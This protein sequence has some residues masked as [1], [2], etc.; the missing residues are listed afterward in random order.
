MS[1]FPISKVVHINHPAIIEIL[2]VSPQAVTP[3]DFPESSEDAGMSTTK[4]RGSVF[5]RD[6]CVQLNRSE[7]SRSGDLGIWSPTDGNYYSGMGVDA[8]IAAEDTPLMNH[9]VELSGVQRLEREQLAK[10]AAEKLEESDRRMIN[11]G[12]DLDKVKRLKRE[13]LAKLAAEEAEESA[14]KMVELAN[15]TFKQKALLIPHPRS[16]AAPWTKTNSKSKQKKHG[17]DSATGAK[18]EKPGV[19]E[20][21][22]IP[23]S[24]TVQNLAPLIQET[25]SN[26]NDISR[27]PS[28][29]A[30]DE[31]QFT[32]SGYASASGGKYYAEKHLNLERAHAGN[33]HTVRSPRQAQD[34]DSRTVISVATAVTTGIV[35][36][37]VHDICHD[38]YDRIAQRMDDGKWKYTSDSITE[39]LKAFAIKIGQGCSNDF[40]RTIMH[41][42]YSHHR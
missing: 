38:I 36:Q 33:T 39:L 6:E 40:N 11:C 7:T 12:M 37:A 30:V 22:T 42:V 20:E 23:V 29:A 2:I 25:R 16:Q 13:Q 17:R 10:L 4:N 8:A 21:F 32:D 41:F 28:A 26:P 31:P 3:K 27:E 5:E 19:A 18:A 14:R 35:P 1:A 15:L 34:D 9:N 24:E